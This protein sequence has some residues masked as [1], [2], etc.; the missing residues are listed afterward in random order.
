MN[1]FQRAKG[2]FQLLNHSLFRF[3]LL[4][5]LFLLVD[6]LVFDEK[7]RHQGVVQADFVEAAEKEEAEEKYCVV[8]TTKVS[9][10]LKDGVGFSGD[11]N[12]IVAC[13][14]LHPRNLVLV[15]VVD[16]R[17]VL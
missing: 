7:G 10:K 5:F 3:R 16:E 15:W 4:L 12:Q 11:P 13:Q 6:L 14:D 8:K 17:A 9:Q 2:R 1:L